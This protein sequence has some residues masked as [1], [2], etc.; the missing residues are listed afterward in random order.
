MNSALREL[1]MLHRLLR[2]YSRCAVLSPHCM[3]ARG[4]AASSQAACSSLSAG[5]SRPAARQA[6]R[7]PL[8]AGVG[9]RRALSLAASAGKQCSPGAVAAETLQVSVPSARKLAC[10]KAIACAQFL[11]Q[12]LLMLSALRRLFPPPVQLTAAARSSRQTRMWRQQCTPPASGW[13]SPCQRQ[14][15]RHL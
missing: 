13:A 4:V 1:P 9:W 15:C 11:L 7:R 10:I 12:L 6:V 2:A 5:A 3:I 8:T 14:Q